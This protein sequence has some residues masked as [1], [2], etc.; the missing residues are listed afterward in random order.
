MIVEIWLAQSWI[1]WAICC[2]GRAWLILLRYLWWSSA[3]TQ[4]NRW[5]LLNASS[6]FGNNWHWVN[7]IVDVQWLDSSSMSWHLLLEPNL[8]GVSSWDISYH[9]TLSWTTHYVLRAQISASKFVLDV[10]Q[11]VLCWIRKTSHNATIACRVDSKLLADVQSIFDYWASVWFLYV[12]DNRTW[13]TCC[14]G[15]SGSASKRLVSIG[16]VVAS[17]PDVL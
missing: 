9:W 3:A 10:L 8:G 5:S 2:F 7:W 13:P 15:S 11:L 6:L 1:L 16:I 4:I 14:I 12:I 17:F